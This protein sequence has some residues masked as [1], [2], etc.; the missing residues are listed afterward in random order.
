MARRLVTTIGESIL[1]PPPVMMVLKIQVIPSFDVLHTE[2]LRIRDPGLTV[3]RAASWAAYG[4][5][6]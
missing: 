4:V 6:R 5:E 3:G 1:M 2:A